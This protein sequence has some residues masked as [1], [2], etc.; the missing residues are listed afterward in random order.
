MADAQPAFPTPFATRTSGG[1]SA[2]TTPSQPRNLFL[3]RLQAAGEREAGEKRRE[4]DKGWSSA[5]R[6]QNAEAS[7][8]WSSSNPVTINM[9]SEPIA[10]TLP[11]Y[12][13]KLLRC[14]KPGLRRGKGWP[15]PIHFPPRSKALTRGSRHR[16]KPTPPTAAEPQNANQNR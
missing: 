3:S 16:R 12:E 5:A 15:P 7:Q 8:Q 13:S 2:V 6:V 4:E 14:A 10:L 9:S 11:R 1:M